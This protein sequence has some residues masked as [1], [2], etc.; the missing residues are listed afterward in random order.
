MAV[1]SSLRW[2]I[3]SASR[4]ARLVRPLG[5]VLVDDVDGQSPIGGFGLCLLAERAEGALQ[6]CEVPGNFSLH[7]SPRLV[8]VLAVGQGLFGAACQ[9]ERGVDRP[10]GVQVGQ[11]G[12]R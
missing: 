7:P 9:R 1:S 3:S 6:F 8:V 11:F 4:A 10:G 2:A 12:L 5:P